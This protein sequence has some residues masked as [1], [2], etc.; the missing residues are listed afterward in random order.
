MANQNPPH[1][2][3]INTASSSVSSSSTGSCSPLSAWY[4]ASCSRGAGQPFRC[5][6]A[7]SRSWVM[8]STF[9]A[10]RPGRRV[11]AP[12]AP[13]TKILHHGNHA[14]LVNTQGILDASG[15]ARDQRRHSSA[16]AR[17]APSTHILIPARHAARCGRPLCHLPAAA[18][19]RT[20]R[21][22]SPC[23]SVFSPILATSTGRPLPPSC[24]NSM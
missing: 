20:T 17:N 2:P 14:D 21:S 3:S 15:S 16:A 9:P 10:I 19:T 11:L 7:W 5:L 1:T 8:N 24:C 6:A 23:L 13:V 18:A 12:H 4:S 22:G